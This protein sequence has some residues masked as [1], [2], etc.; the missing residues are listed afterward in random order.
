[1]KANI[2]TASLV[3]VAGA[4]LTAVG[5][6][7]AHAAAEGTVSPR[8]CSVSYDYVINSKTNYFVPATW[9]GTHL[10]DG[11]GGTMSVSV[12][13]AGTLSWSVTG[14]AEF[15]T[16]A[17]FAKAKVSVSSTVAT[18]VSITVGHTY[19]HNITSNKYGNAQYGSWGYKIKWT[20][21]INNGPACLSHVYATGSATLPTSSTGWK[22][23]ETS[24]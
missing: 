22:Y 21:Y 5:I 11:P 19:T 13:K 2:K 17:I 18:S 20:E 12:T 10:K 6:A 23:W 14:S 9:N 16:S 15:S 24:S 3:G 8:A 1:M 7:P 4:M